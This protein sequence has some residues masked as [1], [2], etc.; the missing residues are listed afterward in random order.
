MWLLYLVA[1]VLI[2][3]A[4]AT[5]VALIVIIKNKIAFNNLEEIF[6]RGE[7]INNGSYNPLSNTVRFKTDR[8]D[9]I[10]LQSSK[11]QF[12]ELLTGFYGEIIYKGNK[13]LSFKRLEEHEERRREMKVDE[14]YSFR[15][16]DQ[17]NNVVDFYADAPSLDISISC[18]E[19]I[20]CDIEEV[21]KYI[22]SIRSNTTDNFFGLDD[23]DNI[24]QFFN[25]GKSSAFEV[26]I[27]VVKKEGSYQAIISSEKKL[28][29]VVKA[30]YKKKDLNQILDLT[31]IQ[32]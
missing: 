15:N 6:I 28:I 24:I 13:L 8:G 20:K 5:I 10:L 22:H 18:D 26:D 2:F 14:E 3:S 16:R 12:Y 27:P 32:F 31:F 29:E 4:V 30:F 1:F 11:K 25:D 9:F 23:G 17:L 19:P 21:L 7:V